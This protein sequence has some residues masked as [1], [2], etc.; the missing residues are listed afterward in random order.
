MSELPPYD[1]IMWRGKT[2]AAMSENELR[3]ALRDCWIERRARAQPKP[4]N[5]GESVKAK[6]NALRDTFDQVFGK[7]R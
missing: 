1:R 4:V 6:V 3:S 7:S 5:G 2:L